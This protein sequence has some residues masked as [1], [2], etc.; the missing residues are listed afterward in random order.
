MRIDCA[1]IALS[2]AADDG[3]VRD[4]IAVRGPIRL[5]TVMR[6]VDNLTLSSRS[7]IDHINEGATG[8]RLWLQ[9]S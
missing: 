9:R 3:P 8:P 4:P 6:K 2:A 1:E 7:H 5:N